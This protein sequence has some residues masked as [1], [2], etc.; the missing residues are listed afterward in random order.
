MKNEM[1]KRREKKKIE[2]GGSI[3]VVE[4]SGSSPLIRARVSLSIQVGVFSYTGEIAKVL[5]FFYFSLNDLLRRVRFSA[6]CIL[7]SLFDLFL[8]QRISRK[9]ISLSLFF[10]L[11][12]R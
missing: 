11:F 1:N 6:P 12:R 3:T 9:K 8:L 7:P 2:V 4:T 10:A 5:I